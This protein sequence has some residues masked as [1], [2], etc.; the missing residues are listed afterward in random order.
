V[1]NHSAGQKLLHSFKVVQASCFPMEIISQ[2]KRLEWSDSFAKSK[3][4]QDIKKLKDSAMLLVL[5]QNCDI[6]CS[7]DCLDSSVELV[8]CKKIKSKDV[9]PASSFVHSVRKLPFE[10]DGNWFEANVDYILTV[11]KADLLETLSERLKFEPLSL[12]PL[13]A[14]TVPIWRANRYNRSALPDEFNNKF[15]PLLRGEKGNEGFLDQLAEV[16]KPDCS[17]SYASFIRAFYY[18]LDTDEEVDSYR[19]E[20]FALVK[21]DVS[22]EILSSIQEVIEQ[23]A[24]EL[25]AVAGYDDDSEIYAGREKDTTVAYLTRLKRF[26]LDSHSLSNDDDDLSPEDC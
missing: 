22:N 6:A 14:R 26:N 21:D 2:E 18:W 17:E 9:S 11:D 24:D 16:S 10:Y 12:A 5:S 25:V 3:Y 4:R 20:F 1:D 7:N 13:F 15:F 23:M 8:V 19:F